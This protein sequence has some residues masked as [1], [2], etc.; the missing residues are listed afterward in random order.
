MLKT[1]HKLSPVTSHNSDLNLTQSQIDKKNHLANFVVKSN[2]SS[3]ITASANK[4]YAYS[5]NDVTIPHKI[6]RTLSENNVVNDENRPPTNL[7]LSSQSLSKQSLL[8]TNS[9]PRPRPTLSSLM[10][11][12]IDG[13]IVRKPFTPYNSSSTLPSYS[14]LAIVDPGSFISATSYPLASTN[15]IINENNG[16]GYNQAEERMVFTSVSI[17]NNVKIENPLKEKFLMQSLASAKRKSVGKSEKVETLSPTEKTKTSSPTEKIVTSSPTEKT[18]TSS[19]I[20]K[21]VTSSPTEKTKT[22]SPIKK[23]VTSSPTE[24]TKMSSPARFSLPSPRVQSN[25][26]DEN[27]GSFKFN[28]GTNTEMN[29]NIPVA[30]PTSI[31]TKNLIVTC[32]NPKID[33]F[34]RTFNTTNVVLSS[35]DDEDLGS[36]SATH[37]DT[38][39]K[40]SKSFRSSSKKFT[41]KVTTAILNYSW[42]AMSNQ[43]TRIGRFF[44]QQGKKMLMIKKIKMTKIE[45]KQEE[46]K[47]NIKKRRLE[48]KCYLS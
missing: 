35:E 13:K 3:N 9:I 44:F 15:Q 45:I 42:S 2:S 41:N 38:K 40:K 19:P 8:S 36:D 17:D 26:D 33:T 43:S 12:D 23:I 4:T 48:H 22:S 11:T 14:C 30:P 6:I 47:K 10:P 39:S 24:K 16:I 27:N 7:L 18:K 28:E 46:Q 31:T 1:G 5:Y 34:A 37:T 29:K 25:L 32:E 21:I 20:K